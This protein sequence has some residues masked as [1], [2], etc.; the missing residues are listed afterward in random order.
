[1]QC[2]ECG[3]FFGFEQIKEG[4]V[5]IRCHNCKTWNI[6]QTKP[7]AEVEELDTVTEIDDTD[8]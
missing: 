2:H 6:Y 5:S 7:G 8:K 1:M 4:E 3:R